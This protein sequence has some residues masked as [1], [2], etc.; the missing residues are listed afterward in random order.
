[1]ESWL[2][3]SQR[4]IEFIETTFGTKLETPSPD[5]EVSDC[6]CPSGHGFTRCLR[7]SEKFYHHTRDT[8]SG[9]R[10]CSPGK[11]FR[12]KKRV[13]K[14]HILKKYDDAGK[15]EKTF[16]IATE[17]DQAKLRKFLEYMDS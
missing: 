9:H 14:I 13:P 6:N 2:V 15:F 11:R 4:K 1:M 16:Q 3:E 5:Q 7:C 17:S 10:L 8:I 12:C